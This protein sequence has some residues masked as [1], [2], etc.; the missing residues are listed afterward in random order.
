M[1]HEVCTLDWRSIRWLVVRAFF[2][3]IEDKY[4]PWNKLDKKNVRRL[5]SLMYTT[6]YIDNI[7]PNY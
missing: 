7:Y 6:I 4:F 3:E 1:F 2:L 5:L